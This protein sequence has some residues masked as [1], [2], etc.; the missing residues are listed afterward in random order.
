[1]NKGYFPLSKG[2][3]SWLSHNCVALAV[4]GLFAAAAFCI[5]CAAQ[6]TPSGTQNVMQILE[7]K[8]RAIFSVPPQVKLIMGPLPPSDGPGYDALNVTIDDPENKP[9]FEVLLA[10]DRQT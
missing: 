5:A 9:Q 4:R 6:P 1:M 10:Q 3:D 7:T 8:V 2:T